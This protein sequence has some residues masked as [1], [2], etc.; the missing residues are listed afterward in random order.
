MK[1]G[2]YEAQNDEKVNR[3]IYGSMSSGG[4]L[5]GGVGENAA[6]EVILAEYDRLG[7]AILLGKNKV[8]MGSFYNFEKRVAREK[9]EVLLV[10]RDLNGVQ[11]E[12][13]EGKEVPIEVKAAEL[14]REKS[15]VRKNKKGKVDED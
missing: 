14:A 3:A 9:P 12:I 1:L 11:V 7:G 2:K 15:K 6:P 10:F 4:Q 5:K 8:K 13:P